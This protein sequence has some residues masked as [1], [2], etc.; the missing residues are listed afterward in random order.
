MKVGLDMPVGPVV[1]ALASEAGE[2]GSN[3]LSVYFFTP[4]LSCSGFVDIKS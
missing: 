3:L 2:H 4:T 1:R